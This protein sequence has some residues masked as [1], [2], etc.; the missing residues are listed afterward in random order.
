MGSEG[1]EVAREIALVANGGVDGAVE[2]DPR[3]LLCRG[4]QARARHQRREPDGGDGHGLAAGVGPAHHQAARRRWQH[5]VV[6]HHRP[7]AR[8]VLG[9]ARLHLQ[10]QQR[11]AQPAQREAALLAPGRRVG[12]CGRVR[13]Q[14]VGETRRGP[15]LVEDGQRRHVPLQRRSARPHRLRQLAEDALF[16]LQRRRLGDGELVAE[17][18]QLLRLDEQRLPAAARVVH[19][20]G[21]V[22]LVLGAHRQHVPVAAHRVVGLAQHRG[23]V[24]VEEHRLQARLDGSVQ[25][26]GALAQ[27]GEQRAR[28]VEQ[29][30]RGIEGALQLDR[31]R[32]KLRQGLRQREVQRRPVS[33]SIDEPSRPRGGADEPRDLQ[34]LLGL[35][36]SLAGGPT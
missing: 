34:D 14:V 2:G 13:A 32:L 30:A 7:R 26:A 11:M 12:Q 22:R 23:H 4:G 35:E 21:Q 20:P 16:L 27:L 24:L 9:G 3:A 8:G 29:L 31:K 17:L 5:H 18:E 28:G 6:R 33:L 15:S 10:H 19:D 1:G 36:R 25:A